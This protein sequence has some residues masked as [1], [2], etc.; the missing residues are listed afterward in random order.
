M[1]DFVT[2]DSS[3]ISW[4]TSWR[5]PPVTV[6][7]KLHVRTPDLCRVGGSLLGD[8]AGAAV[9]DVLVVF[10]EVGELGE[11]L[12]ELVAFD[13]LG[14]DGERLEERLV[15]QSPLGAVGLQ[16]GGLDVVSELEGVIERLEDRLV[17]D[18]M[19]LK[20][21]VGGCALAADPCLFVGVDVFTD[22][23]L[24]AEGEELAFLVVEPGVFCAG[25]AG[26]LFGDLGER[27][28]VGL[29]FA[30]AR[31]SRHTRR[32]RASRRRRSLAWSRQ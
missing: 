10:V 9:G 14:V 16:V 8:A 20:E 27:G 23:I 22:L 32:R 15:E 3:G 4:V 29:G 5:L 19:A 13:L 12:R 31:R 26:L 18:L 21:V 25:A 2:R 30:V 6:H 28:Q 1:P 7:Q 17:L 11:G 24:V